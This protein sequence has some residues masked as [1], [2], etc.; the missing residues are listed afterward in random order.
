[1]I[2]VVILVVSLIVLSGCTTFSFNE[3]GVRRACKSGVVEYD[4]GSTT[5]KCQP[6]K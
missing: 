6:K 3:S 1:M 2:K 5:F 4:D